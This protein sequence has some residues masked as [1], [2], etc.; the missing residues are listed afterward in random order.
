[1]FMQALVDCLLGNAPKLLT[2]SRQ[3]LVLGNTQYQD[4]GF[5]VKPVLFFH[6]LK[7]R[8]VRLMVLAF[9]SIV[10]EF[11]FVKKLSTQAMVSLIFCL[12]GILLTCPLI[13]DHFEAARCLL[14]P[15]R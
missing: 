11:C 6:K 8:F 4:F 15:R 1:M 13:Q 3:R 9:F 14:C 5:A 10:S 12:T 2:D 7:K